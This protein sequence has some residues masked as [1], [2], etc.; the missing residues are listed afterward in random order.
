[1]RPSAGVISVLFFGFTVT[2]GLSG[3]TV[4]MVNRTGDTIVEIYVANNPSSWKTDVLREG[5][6]LNGERLRVSFPGEPGIYHVKA[7]TEGGGEYLLNERHFKEGTTVVITAADAVKD[8]VSTG[9]S[10]KIVNSTGKAIHQIYI[11]PKGSKNAGRGE[12]L[13]G[14]KEVILQGENRSVRFPARFGT[15]VFSIELVDEE[16]TSY[17]RSDVDVSRENRVFFTAKERRL[18]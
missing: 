5:A 1:M 6:M 7:L 8:G 17:F 4:T 10:A 9:F 3:L 18:R 2:T 14:E 15:K 13:L 11:L 12:E 16:G